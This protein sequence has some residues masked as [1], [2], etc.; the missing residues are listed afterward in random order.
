VSAAGTLVIMGSGET[1][2][3]MIKPHRR[4]F[5]RV[6]EAPAVLLDTPYGF[7][8]NADDISARAVTYFAS[9]VGRRVGVVGWRTAPPP[10]LERE[11][12]LSAL[13]AAGWVFAGPGSPTYTLRQ[14]RD[15]P[16]PGLLAGLLER[17]GVLLFASAAALTLGSHTVPVYEV[18]K[19][20]EDPRWVPGLDLVRAVT[21]LPAVVI[22]HFDNAEGGHHDTRFCYLGERRLSRMEADLPD[23]AFVLG[24]DEHTGLVLDLA[25]R[26]ATVVGNGGVTVRRAGRST[27]YPSGSEMTFDDLAAAAAGTGPAG[28]GSPAG[29]V[30]QPDGAAAVAGSAP[31]G[32]AA[33]SLRAAADAA[34]ARFDDGYRRRDVDGCVAAVLDLEAAILDWS[35]DTLTSDEGDHARG[36][37]RDMVVRLGDLARVGAADPRERL[38]P[39]VDLAL[40]QRAGARAA[41]DFAA[42]DR[43]R[44]RLAAAGVQVRDT[45][46]GVEWDLDGPV[47]RPR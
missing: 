6:G 46:D 31:D 1:A 35:A 38:T 36:L 11:R 23:E 29:E 14:W 43:I 9:S 10:G 18:Y 34:A 37:L 20:G 39:L 42:A 5:E 21:G 12:A 13:R 4:I 16:V 26:T 30:P 24:V 15:T 7:Q 44:D 33:T 2:P 45:R 47:P 27:R 40:E 25:A 28:S 32:A 19:A 8:E 22:P 41:R 3:T 17:G